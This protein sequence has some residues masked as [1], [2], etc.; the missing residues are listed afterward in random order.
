MRSFG[1]LSFRP[2]SWVI[3][4]TPDAAMRIKRIFPRMV[5]SGGRTLTIKHTPEVAFELEWALQRFPLDLASAD[6]ERL[7]SQAIAYRSK[8]ARLD[9][10]E[11]TPMLPESFAMTK[12]P[13]DYQAI[14]AALYLEQNFLLLAD[15]VGLGKTITAIASLNGRTLP[16]V[17][18]VKAHLPKQWRDELAAFTPLLRVHIVKTAA[19]YPLPDADVF[20]IS[21]HKLSSWWG[22]LAERCRSV[23]YDEIQELRLRESKK[24]EAA[25][26][27]SSELPYRLGLSATP[28]YNYGGEIWAIFNLLSQDAL[29]SEGEFFREWCTTNHRGKWI[30]CDPEALGTHLYRNKF[31]LRR[32]RREVG[33]LLPP[34]VRYVQDAEFDRAVYEQGSSAADELARII[35]TGTF[36][37]R[38]MAARQFDLKLRQATGLAKAPYVAELVRMLIDSGEKVLLGGW[39]RAVYD[40]WRD[41]LADL[42]PAFF[43]GHE[44]AAQKEA[45]R[46]AFISG[47]TDLLIMSLRS[48]A[49]TNGLQNVCSV[50][51]LGELDWSPKV[52]EQLIGRLA[53]DGQKE[54]VQVFIPVAPV[55]CDPTMASVL[56]LKEAQSTGIIDLGT[57]CDLDLVETDP[58]RLKKLAIDYLE[59]RKISVPTAPPRDS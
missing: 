1:T 16:A 52:H 10:I 20:I 44:S 54:S 19:P 45:A 50:V 31:M 40:V 59:S 13:R 42:K 43:T 26:A 18:V 27:L 4:C 37:E 5:Q 3:E 48:G 24:Y 23:V 38:G 7:A 17:I 30:V 21:Y 35:L 33:R 6:S 46:N 39:H 14:A 15:V 53:R 12:P 25:Q 32:T 2:P 49:G 51:V 8:L 29:G 56:G 36:V 57:D 41:R 11:T 47:Q 28:I 9:Q 22:P 58:Q 34:I 55:G